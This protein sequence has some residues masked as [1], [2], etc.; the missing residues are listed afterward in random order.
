MRPMLVGLALAA[1]SL[2]AEIV[3]RIAATVGSTVITES[4][5]L[6]Q[7]RVSAFINGTA[8]DVSQAN[9]Q[10]VLERLIEQTL[11]RREIELTRFPR[12]TKEQVEPLFK[13]VKA[14][15]PTE[16]AWHE[17]LARAGIAEAQL[18]NQLTWQVMMLRFVEYRFQPS[19]EVSSSQLR[20][21]YRKQAE[22]WRA[23]NHTEPPALEEMKPELERIIRQRL[24]DAAMDRW[25]GEA[26]TRTSILYREGYQ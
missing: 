18:M 10:K 14:P 4:Q 5:V 26:R 24:V 11:I 13:E 12:P 16:E 7:I 3:D 6:D 9:K 15:Y 25:L 1:L 8:P 20:Q 2:H 19:V 17:A 21:E 23:K 22:A